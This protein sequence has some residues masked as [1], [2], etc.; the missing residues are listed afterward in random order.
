ME[1][2]KAIRPTDSKPFSRSLLPHCQVDK[3]K[4]GFQAAE[5]TMCSLSYQ[6]FYSAL[7]SNGPQGAKKRM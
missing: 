7:G 2:H 3:R 4:Q 5:P 6:W 1:Q